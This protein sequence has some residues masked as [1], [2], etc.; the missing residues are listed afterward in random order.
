MNPSNDN[1][2]INLDKRVFI[3]VENSTG[4]VVDDRTEFHFTQ[5]G[6]QFQATYTGGDIVQ[7]HIVGR[8]T[9][10]RT[11]QI[12]YHCLTSNDDLKAGRATANFTLSD[13]GQI[14]M[15]LEWAWVSGGNGSGTSKYIEVIDTEKHL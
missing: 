10:N 8:F 6:E 7:G 15:A 11:A 4:G 12:L 1:R 13:D 9:H 5:V 14:S 2:D 3:P